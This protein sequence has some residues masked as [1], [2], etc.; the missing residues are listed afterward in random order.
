MSSCLELNLRLLNP[1]ESF[2]SEL[3]TLGR[4]VFEYEYFLES[5]WTREY[6]QLNRNINT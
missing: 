3:R 5:S 6:I 1:F 2:W 4:P